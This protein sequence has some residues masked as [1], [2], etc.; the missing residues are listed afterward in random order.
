M[1]KCLA[2][3]PEERWQSA[4]DLAS[5]LKWI[6]E[7]VQESGKQSPTKIKRAWGERWIWLALVSILLAGLTAT[8]LRRGAR[9]AAATWSTILAPENTTLAY[10]AGPVTVSHDG[11]KLAFV[12]TSAAGR[13]MVWVRPLSGLAAQALP[14]TDGASN[15]F[16]SPDDHSIGFFSGGK[17]RTLDAAGPAGGDHLRCGRFSG[18]HVGTERYDSVRLDLGR[19]LS[20]FQFGGAA[21]A[22]TKLDSSRGEL[23]IVG[24]FSCLTHG[25]S[26]LVRRTSPAAAPRA[27]PSMLRIWTPARRSFCFTLAPTR[28][29]R[30]GP[31]C[32]CATEHSWHNLSMKGALRL[33]VNRLLLPSKFNTTNYP[34]EE[35]FRVPSMA[36]SRTRAGIQAR[37]P[38]C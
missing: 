5:E 37:I 17:L 16:W 27:P 18:W 24:R 25:T 29:I 32:F 26:S 23:V 19:S 38:V 22:V 35:F 3:D 14:G 31:F 1:R 7:G 4:S 30:P 12:A 8:F 9:P 13:D 10:F 33:K 34:G 2:K 36:L 28:P 11:R 21:T 20:R 15:P 6:K